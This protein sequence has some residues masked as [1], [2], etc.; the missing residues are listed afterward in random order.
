MPKTNLS[1]NEV[2]KT[3]HDQGFLQSD[4]NGSMYL[5]ILA[6]TKDDQGVE[7]ESEST[8]PLST[9]EG[10][11]AGAI[12]NMLARTDPKAKVLNDANKAIKAALEAGV[13]IP[14]YAL[15]DGVLKTIPQNPIETDPKTGSVVQKAN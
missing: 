4:S 8:L 9:V 15:E 3:L 5:T 2:F 6:K 13:S 10:F 1:R 14:G 7:V 11:S 12:A